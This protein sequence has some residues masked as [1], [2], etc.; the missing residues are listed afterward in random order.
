MAFIVIFMPTQQAFAI[1]PTTALFEAND[2][3]DGDTI[4]SDG[5]TI[6]IRFSTAT[7][8]TNL[9][10]MDSTEFNANFTIAGGISSFDGTF[11]GAWNGDSTELL[12]TW[13]TIGS[14]IPVV[15]STTIEEK[16][17]TTIFD[18]GETDKYADTP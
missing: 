12:I 1:I 18:S 16:G 14:N 17:T 13:T 4:F 7:N 11:T 3:D 15:G 10:T 9:G 8:A 5:D 2:P 6:L